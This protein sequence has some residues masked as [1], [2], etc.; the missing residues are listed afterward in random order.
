MLAQ[1]ILNFS[2]QH[3]F[4]LIEL[5]KYL[6][7]CEV[8]LVFLLLLLGRIPFDRELFITLSFIC[9]NRLGCLMF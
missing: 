4:F 9:E 7:V 6:Q 5:E 1:T 3:K 8:L 2:R